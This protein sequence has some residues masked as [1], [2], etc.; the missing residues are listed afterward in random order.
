[1]DIR[2]LKF[3]FLGDSITECVGVSH[4]SKLFHG[5]LTEQYGIVARNY[6]I[7]GSRIARQQN[8]SNP[9]DRM[10]QYFALRVDEMDPDA[11]V[12]VVFGGTNDF[13]H[14]DA[15]LG[16]PE[17]T[18]ADSFWGGCNLL[19]TKLIEKY[20]TA[21][22]VVITPLHRTNEMN[23]KGD[24]HKPYNVGVLS[25]YV[26]ILKKSAARFSLPVLDLFSAGN[27]QPCVEVQKQAYIPDGLHPND[28][29]HVIIARRLAA[30]LATL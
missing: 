12:I 9:N 3:N 22:I 20:P 23:P 26:D 25:T 24:G 21:T 11:D 17:D 14:G 4:P 7:C 5:L 29:G 15:P 1:M 30:L 2:G 27:M 10:E 18:T 6:G 16:S 8:C 19:F 13:G 28:A